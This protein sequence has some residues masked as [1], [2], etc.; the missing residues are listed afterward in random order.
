M[1]GSSPDRARSSIYFPNPV[2]SLDEFKQLL[3]EDLYRYTGDLTFQALLTT[4]RFEPGFRLTFW[5]RLARFCYCRAATRYGIFHL[6]NWI[7]HRMAIRFGV[8][9]H[10]LTE[11]GG[12]L[13]LPHALAIVVN[14]RCVIG[15]NCNL[16]QNVTLGVANRGERQGT[17]V[18]GDEVFI[19]PGAVVF[20]AIK[21]G[22]RAAIGSNSVVT[23][24][25]PKMGV[26][27]GVPAKLLSVSGS[28]GY[29]NQVLSPL[30]SPDEGV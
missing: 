20:G 29:V 2:M 11:V 25:V 17:P 3:R 4:W 1:L 30:P 14:R 8:Y 22:D 28:T 16:S 18:I 21:V 12:G 10:P 15:R 5:M 13:Y 6:V 9:I 19:G 7:H 27:A 24:D 26:V 23:K